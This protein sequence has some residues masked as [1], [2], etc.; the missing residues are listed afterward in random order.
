M[1]GHRLF[2]SNRGRRDGCGRTIAVLLASV[3]PRRVAG[4]AAVF[5]FL[6][7]LSV[8]TNTAEA[9]RRASAMT[10][11]TGYRIRSALD[12]AGPAIRTALLARAPPPSVASASPRAQLVA[13]L[14]EVLG[15]DLASFDRFQLAFQ[16]SVLP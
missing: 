14:R 6:L 2:C 8:G 3:V 7:A 15:A 9:W 4:A 12:L 13:H 10:L 1:R 16:C 5:A 11:R